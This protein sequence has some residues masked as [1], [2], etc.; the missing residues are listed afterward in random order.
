MKTALE[1][2]AFT[3]LGALSLFRIASDLREKINNRRAY[4]Q[5]IARLKHLQLLRDKRDYPPTVPSSRK[6]FGMDD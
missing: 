5:S 1:V 2:I 6:E 3:V 4:R